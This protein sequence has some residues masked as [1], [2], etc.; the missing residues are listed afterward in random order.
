[1]IFSDSH[2]SCAF[3]AISLIG[4]SST[5]GLDV[6][7]I[8]MGLFGGLALFLY[9]MDRMSDA[10]K[11]VAGDGMRTVLSKLTTNRFTGAIAGAITTSILQSSSVTTVLVVGFISAQL[12]TLTQSIGVIMGAN[13]GTTITAQIIAFNVTKYSLLLVGLGFTIS[14][15]SKNDKFQQ[16]GKLILGLGLIFFGMHLMSEGAYPL[17]SYQP[18]IDSMRQMSNPLFGIALGAVFTGIVQSSSATTGI[19]IVL[20][21]QGLISLETGIALIFGA[22]IGTCVTAILATIGKS[23]EAVRAAVVHVIFNV[24][25][26]LLWFLFIPFLATLVVQISPSYE[27]LNGTAKLGAE[28]PRQIANAHTIF[29]VANTLIFIW[30]TGPIA[31]FVR[32]LVPDRPS[33]EL[34]RSEPKHLDQILLATPSLALDL[35]RMEIG[36]LGASALLMVRKCF[37]YVIDGTHEDLDKL[38]QMDNDVDRLH[39]A[40]ITYLGR[41]SKENLDMNQSE[42]L[43][44]Y[45]SAAN[46]LESIADLVESNLAAIGRQRLKRSI[47]IGERTKSMI[48]DFHNL[49]VKNTKIAIHAIVEHDESAAQQVL[50]AKPQINRFSDQLE[51]HLTYR[52][53][54]DEPNR[55]YTF[56]LE[57]EMIDYLKRVFY[58]S[59]RIAKLVL[60]LNVKS[61][62][63]HQQENTDEALSTA[64]E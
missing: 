43:H 41:L 63:R 55:L 8:F 64:N 38:E 50:D 19:V 52:L 13:I 37:P 36:R 2:Y 17:R 49:I 47:K 27:Q 15:L 23:R 1:M 42:K 7:A 14:F 32:W 40:I 53:A 54:A 12:M 46:N 59:K 20:S 21:S 28:V 4:Q 24:G 56:R 30:F 33:Q 29:N 39:G 11:S 3:C 45:L 16:Y 34:E 31:L 9:G 35:V 44:D 58:F 51:A 5:N 22:N 57:T 62:F 26:V 18:F 25:G 10:L 6:F 61:E 60:E 48:A